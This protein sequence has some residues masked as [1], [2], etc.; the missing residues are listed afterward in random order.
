MPP[1]AGRLTP[2]G[3]TGRRLPLRASPLQVWAVEDTSLQ[4]TWGELAPG[5]V[6]VEAADVGASVDHGGG[7][8]SVVLA[9]LP[10]GAEV[11]VR[12]SWEG[13]EQVLTSCTL[14]PPPGE[15]L[16]R[17]ATVSDLHLGAERWGFLRTMGEHPTLGRDPHPS[18]CARA[19]LDEAAAWGADLLVMKGDLV[20]HRVPD[21]YRQADDLVDSVPELALLVLPGNHDVDDRSTMALPPT[22]G[23]R[24]VPV[25]R[26]VA[27]VDLP[28]IRI[29]GG[30]TT[31][32][33]QGPGT[34]RRIGATLLERAAEADTPVL[35]TL[36]HQPQHYR[37]TTHWP[38]GIGAAEARPFL[39]RLAHIAPRTFVT[40]G[41]THRN[42]ARRHGPLPVTEVASVKDWPGVWA[43][44][45]VHEGGIRQVVRRIGHPEAI[46]WTEYSRHAVL[47][48]W[49]R[50]SPGRLHHRCLTHRWPD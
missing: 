7:P 48:L 45:A 42:R 27:H 14:S 30:D 11:Q 40:A 15:L 41:H 18:R 19:A 17:I 6:T 39:D 2:D 24:R 36:H 21:H 37:V 38:P 22:L 49:D 32:P 35:L 9:G 20:H 29:V 33:G 4:V 5:P 50:W 43:G 12:V 44:Y 34:L 28:G 3:V 31:I 8:G 26:D 46:T 23:R 1:L 47:G 13:G 16:A 25:V 10:A